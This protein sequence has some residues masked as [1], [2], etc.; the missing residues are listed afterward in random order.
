MILGSEQ[1]LKRHMQAIHLKERNFIC[2]HCSKKFTLSGNLG[3]HIRSVHQNK[4]DFQC[5]KC[6]KKFAHKSDMHKHKHV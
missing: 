5:D 2:N 1:Q 4:K 6:D 3:R